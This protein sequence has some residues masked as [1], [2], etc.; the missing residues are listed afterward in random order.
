MET[1]TMSMQEFCDFAGIARS[2]GYRLAREGKLPDHFRIGGTIR[3]EKKA[4][5]DWIREQSVRAEVKA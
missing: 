2:T 5:E 4:V 3:F 1:K